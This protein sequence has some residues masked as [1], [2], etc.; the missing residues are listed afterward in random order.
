MFISVLLATHNRDSIL[1]RTLK[2]MLDLKMHGAEWELIVIDNA[3]SSVT[4]AICEKFGQ[5]LPLLYLVETKPGKNN[6]LNRGLNYAKSDLLVFTDDDVIVEQDWLW[7]LYSAA[8]RYPDHDLFGGKVEPYFPPGVKLDARIVI[9]HPVTRV[10]YAAVDLG[11]NDQPTSASSIWGPNMMVRRR[12][13]NAGLGFD[14][15]IGP[16]QSASYIMGSEAS[17]LLPA[18]KAGFKG[19]YVSGATV[20]HQIRPEQMKFE[21][22]RARAQRMG[23]GKAVNSKEEIAKFKMV[24]GVPRFL[25]RKLVKLFLMKSI[26]RVFSSKEQRFDNEMQYYSWLGFYKQYREGIPE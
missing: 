14:P 26:S 15:N 23:R 12:V 7:Q 5:R 20:N 17:L 25:Y 3:G 21:W 8:Q 4:K 19:M 11:Q 13:F 16:R 2:S 1:E 9:D 24:F 6:A 10:A 22:F 18:E